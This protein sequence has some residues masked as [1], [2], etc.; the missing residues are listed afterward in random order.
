MELSD[1]ELETAR[2]GLAC[3]VGLPL[4]DMFRYL[5]FQKF[6]FDEQKPFLNRKGQPVTASDIGLVV[7]CWWQIS[8]PDDFVLN[9]GHFPGEG[10]RTDQHAYA[11]YESLHEPNPPEVRRIEV[12]PNG[13]L[14]IALSKGLHLSLYGR[15]PEDRDDAWRFMPK[16]DDERGHLVL[17][18]EGLSWTGPFSI[19]NG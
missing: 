5:G 2:E 13:G 11:F 3:L 4:T 17:D 6:E 12:D 16:E 18:S 9:S 1:L 10:P 7:G 15:H 14:E 19:R 8:G